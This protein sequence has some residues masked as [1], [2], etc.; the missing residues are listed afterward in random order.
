MMVYV[1]FFG[2]LGLWDEINKIKRYGRNQNYIESTNI[3]VELV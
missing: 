2:G 3:K 1:F